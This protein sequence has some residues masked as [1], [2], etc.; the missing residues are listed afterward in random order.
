M[1]ILQILPE[2]NMGGVE[3]GTIDLAQELVKQGHKSIIVSHGGALLRNLEK[4]SVKHYTLP[5]HK[6]NPIV[7]FKMIKRVR[8]IIDQENVDLVHA[9]SRV[10]ALISFLACRQSQRIF[11]TTCHGYY[12]KHFFSR[13]MGWGK[14]IIVSS[15]AIGQH[16]VKDFGVPSERIRLIPRGVDLN[17]FK[18]NLPSQSKKEFTVGIVGRITPLKGHI[19][20]LQAMALAVKSIPNLKAWVI[21][22]APA[23]KQDYRK[24]LQALVKQL[25]LGKNVEFLG[26]REDI[27]TL[28]AKLDVLVMATTTPE[29][30]GRVIIE[31]GAIGRPVV[32]TAVGGIVDILENRK[33]GLLVAPKD[34][35]GMAEAV[36]SL[37]KNKEL[38]LSLAQNLRKKVES[39]FSLKQM[40]DKTIKV[41]KEAINA[42]NILVIKISAVGDVVLAIPGLRAIRAK[43]PQARISVLTSS[44]TRGL[45]QGCAYIDNIIVYD[46]QRKD[47]GLLGFWRLGGTL[48]KFSF[49]L[50][51]DLQNN[52]TSHILSFLSAAFKRY[53]YDNKKLSFLLNYKI[54][55]KKEP[56]SPVK[57][58]LQ[59]LKLFGVDQIEEK[60]ELGPSFLDEEYAN[61]FLAKNWIRENQILI[62]LN[63]GSSKKWLTKRWP[64]ENWAKLCDELA[65]KNNWRTVI[66]GEKNDLTLAKE[67]IKQVKTKPIIAVGQ[68]SLTQ[69]AA[70]IKKCQVYLTS[71]SA[72]LHIALSMGVDCLAFFG[73]TDPARHTIPDPKLTILQSKLKC[74]PCYKARCADLDCLKQISVKEVLERVERIIK[75]N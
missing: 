63:I 36:V 39:D 37:W 45:I 18:Y 75:Q 74:A 38:A 31:A 10:P 11:L 30:F 72:P 71:D 50:V 23:D 28:M 9:R 19:Y 1:N 64:L 68:T 66:T 12:Q 7:M 29:A 20:F 65:K 61:N 51:V 60:L 6:K 4:S 47:K 8:E 55:D 69:L 2:L 73:P 48:R 43:F 44:L 49:D 24:Q 33:T 67:L 40:M 27:P 58:Q 22:D 56:I 13:I 15:H 53:G 59:V 25:N 26:R 16:M 34:Y 21:G 42:R 70:L 52:K 41:Y 17:K 5:V 46:N 3:T 54:K 35:A 62:G 57:H 14:L 32:A